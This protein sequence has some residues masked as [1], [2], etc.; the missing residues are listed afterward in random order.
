MTGIRSQ[1]STKTD[2]TPPPVCSELR[3]FSGEAIAQVCAVQGKA[4]CSSRYNVSLLR[5][6]LTIK[7]PEG[8]ETTLTCDRQRELDDVQ[9]P[10]AGDRVPTSDLWHAAP[11]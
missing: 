2:S 7:A 6:T 11:W 5:Q 4:T 3:L 8:N 9:D 1:R 10:L